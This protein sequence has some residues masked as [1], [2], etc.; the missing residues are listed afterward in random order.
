MSL[1][2][3]QE[4]FCEEYLIDLNGAAAARRAGYSEK[5]ATDTAYELMQREDIQQHIEFLMEKRRQ[6]I[7]INQDYVLQSLLEISRVGSEGGRIRSLELIGKH[8][9]M[10]NEEIDFNINLAKKA[11]EYAALPQDKQIELI[12]A[13]LA[14]L[15]AKK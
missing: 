14:K 13:E 12:E 11:E 2:R 3:K 4:L 10:F 15:K 1:N 9:R 6:K 7:G 5:S 8:Q